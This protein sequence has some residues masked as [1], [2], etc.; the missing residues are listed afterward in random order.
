MRHL[1][2]FLLFLLIGSFAFSQ[3]PIL[4]SL[5]NALKDHPAEDTIRLKIIFDIC[6]REN[7]LHP[8]KNKALA[9][10]ALNIAKKINPT[11]GM[12]GIGKANRYIALYYSTTGDYTQAANY[13]YEALRV[14]ER[15]SDKRG[16]G[17]AN[18]L[19]GN[20][21]LEQ[22]DSE[23]TKAKA[24]YEKALEIYL[25]ENLKKEIGHAYNSLGAYYIRFA[26]YDQAGEYFLKSLEVRKEIADID[27]LS[28]CYTNLA[29]VYMNQKKYTEALASFEKALPIL[30]KLDNQYRITV[31]YMNMGKL[32]T[33]TNRFDKAE[34]YLFKSLA[35][36]KSIHH[37]ALLYE[38]Y[39]KLTV[40][41]KKRGGFENALKYAELE[42]IYHDSLYT[43]DKAK[44]IADIETRYETEKK[45][46]QI[47]LLER[48]KK[49]QL[50]WRNIFITA[51]VLVTLLSLVVYFLQRYSEHK[52]RKI[53]N[54]QID[55]LISQQKELSVKYKDV[56]TSGDEKSLISH[57][58]RLLRKAIEL[59][60]KKMSD[61]L[62][63]VEKMAEEIG[64]SR[65]NMH[66]KIKAITG[67]PPSELIRSIRLR[68][69]ALLLRNETDS[70]SQISFNVGFEDHS[71]FSKAFKKQFGVSPS[72]YV[73]SSAQSAD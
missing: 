17:Q 7:T 62:F 8:E 41:E 52:N 33:L 48:D 51:L 19:L 22:H 34:F 38:I 25:Q 21:Y 13:A 4:D 57:D 61:P 36:A 68:K 59:V 53:L 60:E 64:M 40:L 11:D 32:Y 5:Y 44:Q 56:I 47:Q 49:I 39:Y 24:F 27:G 10:E 12:K 37:K 69:A 43:R 2:L 14:L 26:K 20:I 63:S 72:E 55:S 45:N 46:Q 58:Q 70:I 54:L 65:T 18:E 1:F 73:E 9:E 29:S 42:A 23:K 35:T 71:Y 50:L 30:Q 6:Y 31:T 67:F 16:I 28:Q 3:N 15:I 66:R